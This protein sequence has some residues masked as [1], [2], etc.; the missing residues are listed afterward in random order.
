MQENF[1]DNCLKTLVYIT[2]HFEEIPF[3]LVLQ[4]PSRGVL[5]KRC[6]ENMQQI[7][8]KHPCQS[9]ISLNLLSNFI[10]ITLRHGCSPVY[11]LL[12]K[13][14]E[15]T[16]RHGRSPVNLLFCKFIEIS[17]QHG[18]SLVILLYIFRIPFPKSTFGQF[19]LVLFSDYP[20]SF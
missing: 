2:C 8:R 9:V 1:I 7:Y 19:L 17:L 15:I 4:N 6:S 11:F 5:K 12:C 16:L 10:E 14:F 20:E 13:F 3:L 18:C